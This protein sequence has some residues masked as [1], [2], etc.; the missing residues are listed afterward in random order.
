MQ[1]LQSFRASDCDKSLYC[2]FYH[3]DRFFVSDGK[4]NCI[5]VF[6]EE[7][8]FLYIIGSEGSGDGQLNRPIGLAIDKFNNLIVC[9][10]RNKRLQIFR[11]DG[12]FVP[13]IAEHFSKDDRVPA[14]VAVSTLFMFF[15]SAVNKVFPDEC[16]S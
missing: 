12:T 2:A 8:K 10:E 11:L 1:L 4:A 15:S 7:R 16:F 6:S 5:K 13:K 14:Y 9:D 3:Q